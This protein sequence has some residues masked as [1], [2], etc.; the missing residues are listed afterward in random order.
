MRRAMQTV[1]T[2]TFVFTMMLPAHATVWDMGDKNCYDYIAGIQSK[3]S[4]LTHHMVDDPYFY[5]TGAWQFGPWVTVKRTTT[6]HKDI[7][8]LVSVSGGTLYGSSTYAY[9]TLIQ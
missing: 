8:W 6:N 3:S 1:L 4:G 9:C 7:G 5:Y 2:L